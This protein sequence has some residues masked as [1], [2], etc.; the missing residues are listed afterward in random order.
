MDR[1]LD[2]LLTRIMGACFLAVA[3]AHYVAGVC[4][5]TTSTQHKHTSI[6]LNTVAAREWHMLGTCSTLSDVSSQRL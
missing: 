2:M 6:W 3:A 4:P 1:R 5:F